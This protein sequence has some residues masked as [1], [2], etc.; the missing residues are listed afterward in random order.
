MAS[1]MRQGALIFAL[2]AATVAV[3]AVA[4]NVLGEAVVVE[5]AFDT[6]R[7]GGPKETAP[8]VKPRAAGGPDAG[9]YYYA[10]QDEPVGPT[11][12]FEDIS[13]TGTLLPLL[14][15]EVSGALPIGFTF[16]YYGVDYSDIYVSS[17]GFITPVSTTDDGCC[18]G[19]AL[20]SSNG[21]DAIIAGWWA[22]LQPDQGGYGEALYYQT[23]G[24]SPNRRFIVQFTDVPHYFDYV[25][26]VTMQF[27]LFEGTNDIEVHYL[28]APSDGGVHSAGIE[29]QDGTIGLQYARQSGSLP[30]STVVQYSPDVIP[31]ELHSF[32][33]E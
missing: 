11:Y 8:V 4:G 14:D 6:K 22:D 30:S 18:S 27:K 1:S 25:N 23:L 29:N 26:L 31:V 16:S 7:R 28:A 32:A 10:D 19:D 9:G 15:D 24:T 21:P 3:L 20:P 2:F 13:T 5:D 17:N 12:S 33:V